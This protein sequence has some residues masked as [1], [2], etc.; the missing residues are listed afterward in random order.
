[1][2]KIMVILLMIAC[3]CNLAAAK[4]WQDYNT[5]SGD[6]ADGDQFR[7]MDTSD[8]TDHAVGTVK[9]DT[10]GHMREQLRTDRPVCISW[11]A[12]ETG[13]DFLVYKNTT[14]ETITIQNIYG[15]LQGG[16]N[17]VGGFDECNSAGASCAAVDS[18]ITFDGGEDTDDGTLTNPTI[19]SLDYIR[20]HTTTVSSPTWLIVCFT[21]K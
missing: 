3:G 5:L 13:D 10:W 2:K 19:D 17:V 20:W 9:N 6:L 21:Y 11:S 4:D 8:T 16:T 7:M 18:D 14:G 1:M 12:P 15:V